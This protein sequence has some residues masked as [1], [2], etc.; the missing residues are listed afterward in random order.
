MVE[1]ILSCKKQDARLAEI[2]ARGAPNQQNE[3]PGQ[4]VRATPGRE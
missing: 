3:I 4:R 1:G 2:E